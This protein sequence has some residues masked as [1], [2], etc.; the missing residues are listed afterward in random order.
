MLN[1]R[2]LDFCY[3]KELHVTAHSRKSI[4]IG[5]FNDQQG[6]TVLDSFI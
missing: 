5:T 2:S 3:V 6:L 1:L 4:V